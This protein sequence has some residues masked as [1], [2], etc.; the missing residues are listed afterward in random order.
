MNARVAVSVNVACGG[1]MP[2]SFFEQRSTSTIYRRS[3]CMM[4]KP[5]TLSGKKSSLCM[6]PS[7]RHCLCNAL[8]E[9]DTSMRYG[10]CTAS[11]CQPWQPLYARPLRA[12]TSLPFH[13][14]FFRS[15]A[16]KPFAERRR[17]TGH[18]LIDAQTHKQAPKSLRWLRTGDEGPWISTSD[19]FHLIV[20][21]SS[22]D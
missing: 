18:S 17:C 1:S 5:N 2:R 10:R 7:H 15:G 3:R 11:S 8:Y 4:T 20:A 6:L 12:S 19:S 13:P 9:C 16:A 21:G 14:L 22:Q